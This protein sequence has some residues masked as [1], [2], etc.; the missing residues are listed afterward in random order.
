[1]GSFGF[2]CRS[3][4]IRMEVSDFGHWVRLVNALRH[5]AGDRTAAA[6]W[7]SKPDECGFD[8]QF[9][10]I[11]PGRGLRQTYPVTQAESTLVKR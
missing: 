7:D 8:I 1:M 5:A 3:A 9:S 2:F 6:N 10:Q 11:N 4:E